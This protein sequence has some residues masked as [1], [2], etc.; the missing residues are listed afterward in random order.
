MRQQAC[1]KKHY[2]KGGNGITHQRSENKMKTKEIPA[3]S[4]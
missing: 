1:P 2:E 3:K 4:W